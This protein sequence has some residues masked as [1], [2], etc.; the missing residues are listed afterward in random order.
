MSRTLDV[1]TRERERE[2]V[3]REKG[4]E[5]ERTFSFLLPQ[6]GSGDRYL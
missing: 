4:T 5:R 6:D 2:K 1:K 3:M